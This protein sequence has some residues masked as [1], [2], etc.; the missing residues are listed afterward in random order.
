MSFAL[1]PKNLKEIKIS[2]KI[3]ENNKERRQASKDNVHKL[4]IIMLQ[5]LKM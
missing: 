3:K 4:I 2:P 5:E 1:N